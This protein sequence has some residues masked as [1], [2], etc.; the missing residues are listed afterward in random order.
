MKYVLMV[1]YGAMRLV[2]RFW[3]DVSNLRV[4]EKIACRTSRGTEAGEVVSVSTIVDDNA[5]SNCAGEVLR[6][7]TPED[8]EHLLHLE[9][10]VEPKAYRHCADCIRELALP[11]QLVRVEQLLGGDKIVFYFL[12]EGRV[13]FRELVKDL[14]AKYRTRIEMRQI[15][16]RDEARLLA[17]VEHCGR[18]LCC[19]TFIKELEPVTMRMAKAQKSTLDPAKISGR[20]GRLMCCLR[21][22]DKTYAYLKSLLPRKGTRVGTPDGPGE[23]IGYEILRQMVNVELDDGKRTTAGIDDLT[24]L[25]GEEAR[26]S[27]GGEKRRGARRGGRQRS[28]GQA[29]DSPERGNDDS[30]QKSSGQ[31]DSGY[32]GKNGANRQPTGGSRSRRGG[33]RGGKRQE[34]KP[35]SES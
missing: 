24:K 25:E 27:G 26:R 9:E 23:V 2:G 15:G 4:N 19:R 14:A 12:A 17:E 7:L 1:R 8:S 13:D 6:R 18:E 3:T 31:P 11:M 16:V 10:E 33:R 5:V 29:N 28:G 35:N 34:P 20:C 32:D 22:E 30:R 21:F